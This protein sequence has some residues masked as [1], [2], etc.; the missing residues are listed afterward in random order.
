[1]QFFD[2]PLIKQTLMKEFYKLS[3]LNKALV[4]LTIVFLIYGYLCR[5]I[6]LYFFWESKTI[7]WTL[8][9]VT[10]I[11]ILIQ[12]IKAK[13]IANK[14]TLSEKIFIGI[15]VFVLLI[16]S[17]I[18]IIIPQTDA[19]KSAKLFLMTDKTIA[20]ELGEVNGIF[21]VPVSG[22]SMSS[23]SAGQ[24]GQADLNF[25]VKGKN[26]FKDINLQLSKELDTNWKILETK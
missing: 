4:R 8:L 7:G 20:D 14:K 10:I 11:S 25:I 19:Y 24:T 9:F 1:V 17:I 22:M 5:I 16:Q 13:K 18:F 12:R 2:T 3:K 26:K 6:G 23:N 15:I 21:L